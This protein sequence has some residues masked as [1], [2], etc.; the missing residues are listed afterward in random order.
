MNEKL[1]FNLVI[2]LHSQGLS[3][4][5]IKAIIAEMLK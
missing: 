3:K 4:E 2:A 5:E 1:L